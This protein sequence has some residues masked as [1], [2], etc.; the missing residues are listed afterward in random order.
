MAV[1]VERIKAICLKPSAEWP[2]IQAEPDSAKGLM[3]GYAAPLAAIGPVATFIGGVLIGRTIPF[4]GTYHIPIGSGLALAV[5]SYLLSLVGIFVL[6]V[7]I[8][9]LAPTFGGQKDGTQALKA[10]VYAYTPGWLAG[11][12]TILTS[13]SWLPL[14]AGFYG[15]YLFYLGLPILMKSPKEKAAGYTIVVI[16]CAIVLYVVI[17]AVVAAVGGAG[18][19]AAGRLNGLTRGAG[20]PALGPGQVQFDKDSLL[21]KMQAMGQAAEANNKRME[22][23]R[24]SGDV[25]AQAQLA[26]QGLAAILGGGKRVTPL[27]IEQL[28]PFVPATF[29][30]LGR[31]GGSAEKN[32]MAG[33][34]VSKAEGRYGDHGQKHVTLEVTDTGG[35]SGLV[36]LA[37]WMNLQGERE[38][39]DGFEKTAKV[40]GRLMHEK[41]SKH[42][43]G[44]NEFT[45]VLGDRFVV[46]AQGTGVELAELKA[47]VAGLELAKLE[48][49]KSVGVEN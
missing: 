11:I 1:M 18:M 2:V 33:L 25:N 36:G 46:S 20:T 43:G 3:L 39:E 12:F 13:L 19:M 44:R 31:T 15:L 16:I 38:D 41:G 10:A 28:K 29:A 37:G 22:A 23:A 42:P 24:K 26:M 14:V 7:I 5:M 40:D 34:S 9:A 47:G 27:G 4:I 45:V 6:S 8:N 30:G 21:G 32:G 49:L 17:G 35:A 48:A